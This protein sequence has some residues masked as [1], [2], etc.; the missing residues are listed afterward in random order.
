MFHFQLVLDCV[1]LLHIV[2]DHVEGGRCFEISDHRGEPRERR[3]ESGY[4]LILAGRH[5]PISYVD[6]WAKRVIEYAE[7]CANYRIGGAARIPRQPEPG[8]EVQLRWIS[9]HSGPP[10]PRMVFA[11]LNAMVASPPLRSHGAE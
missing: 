1:R 8:R 10:I 5:R 9:V 11:A 4:A 2:V 7:P 6:T 3:C